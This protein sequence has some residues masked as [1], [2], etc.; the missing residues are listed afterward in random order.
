MRAWTVA[1]GVVLVAGMAVTA[2]AGSLTQL[3]ISS[4]FN[5]DV[6]AGAEESKEGDWLQDGGYISGIMFWLSAADDPGGVIGEHEDVFSG[7]GCLVV[8]GA[9]YR[10]NAG[11]DVAAT[12]GL[13]ADGQIISFLSS[14]TYNVM[15]DPAEIEIPDIFTAGNHG[16]VPNMIF[17]GK[18]FATSSSYR[19]P[20]TAEVNVVL[21]GGQQQAYSVITSSPR[22]FGGQ[23]PKPQTTGRSTWRSGPTTPTTRARC[24]TPATS[25]TPGRRTT[26][27]AS[28]GRSFS[29]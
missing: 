3:D 8:T 28:G 1:L 2:M 18:N 11:N 21:D 26:T 16:T 23:A 22:R 6:I 19:P 24:S 29:R 14:F 7:Q 27:A 13:P 5:Y 12:G 4:G 15:N 25:T 17:C 9:L 20:Y 10:N